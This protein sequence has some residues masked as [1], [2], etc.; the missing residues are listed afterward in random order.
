MHLRKRKEVNVAAPSEQRRLEQKMKEERGAK[1]LVSFSVHF[2][3]LA[4]YSRRD[5]KPLEKL[6]RG[7]PWNY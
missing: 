4:F 3:E 2:K 1:D 6:E 7:V 5:E